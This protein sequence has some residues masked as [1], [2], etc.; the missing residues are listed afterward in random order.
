MGLA[1]GSTLA[2]R[3]VDPVYSIRYPRAYRSDPTEYA[4]KWTLG[5]VA[6]CGSS[7]RLKDGLAVQAG[8]RYHHGLAGL[9]LTIGEWLQ[10]SAS[11]W[12]G[13]EV[14]LGGKAG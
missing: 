11:L 4:G 1:T 7:V 12:F 2:V 9:D 6:E 14:V 3:Y 5:A 10:R 13:L 8:L